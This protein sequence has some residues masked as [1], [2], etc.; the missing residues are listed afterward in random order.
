MRI[1]TPLTGLVLAILLAFLLALFASMYR[2]ERFIQCQ[3]LVEAD[4]VFS[5]YTNTG[6]GYSEGRVARTALLASPLWQSIKFKINDVYFKDIRLDFDTRS[7][8]VAV[9]RCLF[10]DEYALDVDQ[11]NILAISPLHQVNFA[12]DE[13]ND[14]TQIQAHGDDPQIRL[15]LNVLPFYVQNIQLG[16]FFVAILLCYP[17]SCLMLQAFARLVQGKTRKTPSRIHRALLAGSL[18]MWA[19]A[20]LAY[21]AA[22]VRYGVQEVP[23]AAA[24]VPVPSGFQGQGLVLHRP[25]GLAISG[26]LYQHVSQGLVRGNILLLHGN[27]PQGQMFPLYP[28]MAEALAERGFRVLTIDFAGFGQSADPFASERHVRSDLESET[29]LALGYLKNLAAEGAKLSVIGHSM[30][31]NPALRVGL[32]DPAVDSLILIGPPRRVGDRFHHR[33]DLAFFWNWA[34]GI[35]KSQYGREQF[36]S[37]YTQEQWQTYFLEHDMV[38]VLPQLRAW[39]HKPLYLLDGG[40]EPAED[41]AFLQGY[42]GQVSAPCTY[43]TLNG[44]DHNINVLAFQK[45]PSYEPRAL[46]EAVD[47]LERWCEYDQ[48]PWDML[49]SFMQNV[50]RLLFPFR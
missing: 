9:R 19:L 7:K 42:A 30:G 45:E 1:H 5:L 24:A 15:S 11:S 43:L 2:D 22:V 48:G 41:H 31:A 6:K 27:Y 4:T 49:W 3:V 47:V 39:G 28:L 16:F 18:F 14:F 46:Q 10:Q 32:N 12:K 26:R 38:H 50:L 21:W 34:L 8:T 29:A 35:S 17:F 40:G 20:A 36:P 37:W 44:V 33:G 23:R 25:D 13:K